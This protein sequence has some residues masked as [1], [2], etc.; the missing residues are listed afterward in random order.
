MG[1]EPQEVQAE[2]GKGHSQVIVS[3]V[4]WVSLALPQIQD[5]L[6]VGRKTEVGKRLLQKE[7]VIVIRCLVYGN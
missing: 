2:I 5:L 6:R 1:R 4:Y 3:C 7:S